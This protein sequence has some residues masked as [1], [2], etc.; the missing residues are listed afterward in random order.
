MSCR[1]NDEAILSHR[2]CFKSYAADGLRETVWSQQDASHGQTVR[3]GVRTSAAEPLGNT[4][5]QSILAVG[6]DGAEVHSGL[7]CYRKDSSHQPGEESDV[8]TKE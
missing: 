4:Q 8:G 1:H 7:H 2:K 5:R 6:P 3:H